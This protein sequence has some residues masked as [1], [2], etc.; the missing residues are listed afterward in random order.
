MRH[1][2]IYCSILVITLLGCISCTA[3]L[4]VESPSKFD[5]DYVFASENEAFRAVSGIYNPILNVY[6]GRWATAYQSNTDVEFNDVGDTPNAKGSDFASFEP[7]TA[8][9]DIEG[10]WNEMYKGIN[11][12]NLVING[13]EKSPLFEEAD[14]SQPST[15]L[16]L[17]GEAKTLRAMLYHDAVRTWGDIPFQL[18]P[19]VAGQDF[20]L[21]PTDRNEILSTLIEDL[22]SVE[23]T[24]QYAS[25]ISFGGE[26]ASREYCQG[27]I[28]QLA[29]T[30]GGYT[31]RPDKNNPKAVGTMERADDWRDYYQIAEKYAGK[32]IEDG[33]HSL[34]RSF[35]QVWIDEMNYRVPADDD[36]IFDIALPRNGTGEYAYY[37]GIPIDSSHDGTVGTGTNPYGKASGS[38]SMTMFYMLSFDKDDLRRDVTCAIHRF[39]KTLHVNKLTIGASQIGG[40]KAAKYNRLRMETPLGETTTKSPGVNATYMRY[41]DILLMYAEA[42]N[43][44]HGSPT[45]EAKEALKTV[46]RRAFPSEL[47]PTKVED[48]VES[49]SDKDSFFE[50]IFNERRW[51]F[52]GEGKRRFELAR[53]N[54]YGKVLKDMFIMAREAGRYAQGLGGTDY[55]FSKEFYWHEIEDPNYP[56]FYTAEYL[57]LFE[58]YEGSRPSGW[59]TTKFAISFW[60]ADDTPSATLNRAFRGYFTPDTV[61]GIDPEVTPVRYLMPFSTQILNT[62]SNLKNYYGF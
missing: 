34:N 58:P 57:G 45:P 36:I 22:I 51:E 3:F 27:L 40:V 30:R 7:T 52:G 21:P 59:N 10:V 37:V 12:A 26:R 8:W 15:I 62:N 46:R 44:N 9:T 48:Y 13:I 49:L 56:G 6:G 11:R 19:T 53:W 39:D 1:N 17:Y 20:E 60:N 47:W 5:D 38:Y 35:A 2:N 42:A 54:L 31:L 23:P 33:R 16:Q 28:A 50:A 4:T 55:G 14:K 25:Q 29:L 18:T 24:M 41:A 43:E 61:D 32:V